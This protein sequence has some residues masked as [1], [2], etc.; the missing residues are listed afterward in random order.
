MTVDPSMSTGSR[1]AVGA[2]TPV[3]P[4]SQTTSFSTVCRS[5]DAVLYPVAVVAEG[6]CLLVEQLFS[7]SDCCCMGSLK[8]L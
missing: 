6:F 7:A 2:S 8:S 1:I 4:T 3:R 5:T